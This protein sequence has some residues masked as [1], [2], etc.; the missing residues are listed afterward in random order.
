MYLRLA[1][2]WRMGGRL[3][4]AGCEFRGMPAGQARRLMELGAGD[5]MELECDEARPQADEGGK[6]KPKR[7]AK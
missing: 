6:R 7:Q 1:K 5:V 4:P 2:P 3:W